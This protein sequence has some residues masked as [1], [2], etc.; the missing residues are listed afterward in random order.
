MNK[1]TVYMVKMSDS[2]EIFLWKFA[3]SKV[4]GGNWIFQNFEQNLFLFFY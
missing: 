2:L 3:N 4:L 1:L